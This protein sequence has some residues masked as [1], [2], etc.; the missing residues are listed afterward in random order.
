M[1]YLTFFTAVKKLILQTQS[2][3]LLAL[4]L[5]LYLGIAGQARNDKNL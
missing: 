3:L 2:F 1:I 5:M 4:L